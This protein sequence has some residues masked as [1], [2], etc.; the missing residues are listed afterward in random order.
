MSAEEEIRQSQFTEWFNVQLRRRAWTQGKL[1]TQSGNTKE[2][3]LSSAAVS[4]YSTG[5]MLPDAASCQKIARALEIPVELVLQKAGLIE[6][7][8]S[9]ELDWLQRAIGDLA[10]AVEVGQLS[11][12]GRIAITAH[13]HREQLLQELER[14]KERQI[15]RREE[16]EQYS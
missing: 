2:E 14:E 12:E 16:T 11:E 15:E 3:R 5:K 10:Y 7:P 4:R 9:S 1:I 13:I 8:S 6:T